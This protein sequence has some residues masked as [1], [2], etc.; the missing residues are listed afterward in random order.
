MTIIEALKNAKQGQRISRKGGN[1]FW[2]KGNN[3]NCTLMEEELLADDWYINKPKEK[4]KLTFRG[5]RWEERKD[6][7][8]LGIYPVFDGL[9]FFELGVRELPNKPPMTMTLE[10]EE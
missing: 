5:V 8:F 7:D 4:K 9:H 3:Q 10:W 2:V 6:G 1:F